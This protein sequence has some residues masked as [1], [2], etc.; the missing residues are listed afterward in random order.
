MAARAHRIV[1]GARP[2]SPPSRPAAGNL[3]SIERGGSFNKGKAPD[4]LP[5]DNV[6]HIP[7]VAEEAKQEAAAAAEAQGALGARRCGG[8]RGRRVAYRLVIG[9]AEAERAPALSF[10]FCAAS[11]SAK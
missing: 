10:S 6:E 4:V 7:P 9:A 1:R 8:R 3:K 5:E 2:P 11:A